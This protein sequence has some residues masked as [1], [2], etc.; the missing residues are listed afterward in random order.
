VYLT[1]AANPDKNPN[2]DKKIQILIKI[3]KS[4]TKFAA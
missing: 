3:N 2:P 1:S 4:L